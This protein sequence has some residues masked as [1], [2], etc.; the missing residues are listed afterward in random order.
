MCVKGCPLGQSATSRHPCCINAIANRADSGHHLAATINTE[1][2]S[3]SMQPSITRLPAS[4][5]AFECS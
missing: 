1:G 4:K 2:R 5:Q 3:L